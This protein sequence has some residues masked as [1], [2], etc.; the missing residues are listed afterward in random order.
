MYIIEMF[1]MSFFGTIC[2]HLCT[3]PLLSRE[4]NNNWSF[5]SFNLKNVTV[6]KG[7]R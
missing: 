7:K 3:I 5:H 2:M 6:V 4:L 1:G